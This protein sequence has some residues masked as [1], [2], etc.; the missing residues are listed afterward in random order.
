MKML[1]CSG[2]ISLIVAFLTAKCTYKN[3]RKQVIAERRETLYCE[4]IDFLIN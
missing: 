1:I 4:T 3:E 2:I